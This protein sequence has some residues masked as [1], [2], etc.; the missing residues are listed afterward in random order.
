MAELVAKGGASLSASDG[1]GEPLLVSAILRRDTPAALW[2]IARGAKAGAKS[3]QPR[4]PT[5]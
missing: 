3:G 2:L 1:F 4:S 5:A